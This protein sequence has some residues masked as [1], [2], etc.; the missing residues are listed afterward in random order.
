MAEAFA[1]GREQCPD[2]RARLTA[3]HD[4]RAAYQALDVADVPLAR[5]R[6][7][8]ALMTLGIPA[9]QS[10]RLPLQWLGTLR[11]KTPPS[12]RR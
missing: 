8:L 5:R 9:A 10:R 2:P 6:A 12:R 4:I 11:G 3:E 7:E 1:Q